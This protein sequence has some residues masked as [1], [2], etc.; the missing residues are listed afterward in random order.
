MTEDKGPWGSLPPPPE[1]PARDRGRPWLWLLL[2]ASLGVLVLALHHAFPEA[3][4]SGQEWVGVAGRAGIVVLI[5]AGLVSS[6]SRFRRQHLKYAAL[7]A[8]VIAVL[9]LGVAYRDLFEDAGRRLALAFSNGDPVAVSAHELVVPQAQDGS[10]MVVGKVN[11][12]RV[13]FT[14]DT[15]ASETVL[16]PADARRAGLDVDRLR[17]A[18]EAETANGVGYGAP[19]VVDRLD[20]GPIAVSKMPV[21]VNKAPMST[22]LLGMSFLHRLESFRI[23][24]KQ[25]VLR[26]RDGCA[27][28]GCR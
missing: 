15:G 6:R 5:A 25:L 19:A 12:Q 17:Y 28:G 23:E 26:W 13:A 7:W 8:M 3:I 21:V 14:V 11:G 1:P 16:S 24:N 27:P 22:S 10:Y 20:V 9:A 2:L 18:L 4:T